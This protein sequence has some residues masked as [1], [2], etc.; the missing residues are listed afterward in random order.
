MT[1]RLDGK[2]VMYIETL[3]AVCV[4]VY[5]VNYIFIY[6]FSCSV[7]SVLSDYGT[8]FP[9][10][11]QRDLRANII[12]PDEKRVAAIECAEL[13]SPVDENFNPPTNDWLSLSTHLRLNSLYR[14]V[15]QITVF[16]APVEPSMDLLVYF[17]LCPSFLFS[18]HMD[19][20]IQ[21]NS[22]TEKSTPE[23]VH[24]AVDHVKKLLVKVLN[25]TA[26]YGD[27]IFENFILGPEI[28]EEFSTLLKCKSFCVNG[29]AAAEL[30][31][32]KSFLEVIQFAE[33][34]LTIKHVFELYDDGLYCL[35]N[36]HISE[37]TPTLQNI[38]DISIEG[39]K[40]KWK[41]VHEAFCLEEDASP[42]HLA[43]ELF[44]KVA[45]SA[46][47]Y[48]FLREKNLAHL[49]TLD[50]AR[51]HHEVEIITQHQELD[52]YQQMVLN[53][54]IAAFEFI[55]PIMD[56]CTHCSLISAV[57]ALKLPEGLPQLETVR[58]NMRLIQ[59]WFSRS[60][61]TPENVSNELN[62]ILESGSYHIETA[63]SDAALTRRSRLQVVLKYKLP[64]VS[65]SEVPTISLD[66][67]I[68]ETQEQARQEVVMTT[69]KIEDFVHRI[70]LLKD[71]DQNVQ[72]FLHLNKV[73]MKV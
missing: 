62:G 22:A 58:K 41:I 14:L 1:L 66:Q 73:R 56:S 55:A 5:E 31:D 45:D 35:Y 57:K 63:E 8:E 21:R 13:P 51:F 59:F 10:E 52:E 3:I 46:D 26:T 11:I 72:R 60:E 6:F 47:F 44:F 38:A 39:A 53:H 24:M 15:E 12:L 70:K 27:I 40:Q 34:F 49:D 16:L 2:L 25:G 33:L 9:Q 69:E 17:K 37:L 68:P 64:F 4:V 20:A 67:S 43:I 18:T 61:D 23:Q 28:E 48:H 65:P 71:E 19:H 42:K 29:A 7:I 54:L 32:I 50:S 30:T 36:P